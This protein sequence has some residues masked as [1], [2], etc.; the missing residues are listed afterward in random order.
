M[1]APVA[2]IAEP[3]R[4]NPLL[5]L[6]I[7]IA[8]RTTGKRM[9]PARLLAWYP[10]AAVS[11][12]VLETLIAHHD[13]DLSPRELKLVRMTASLTTDCAF[14]IDM[15]SF[16]YAEVGLTDAEAASLRAGQE[17]NV[18]TF[19]DREKAAIALTRAAS[20]S[21]LI[22]PDTLRKHVTSLFTEREIV[23]LA[24]TAAQVNYWARLIQALGIPPAGYSQTC[25]VAADWV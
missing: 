20:S 12:G 13:R 8:E 25:V 18:R 19:T 6:G 3:R 15:N 7:I 21:P 2:M 5:R 10:K 14:C 23:I 24:T 4:I 1:V 9:L 11:S 16:E 22:F 17:L